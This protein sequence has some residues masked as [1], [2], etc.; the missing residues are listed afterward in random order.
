MVRTSI[1]DTISLKSLSYASVLEI[2]DTERIT[3]LSK[4]LAVQREKELFFGNEGSFAAY[5][6][7]SKNIP[8]PTIYER[9]TLKR[10]NQNPYIKVGDL[11]VR[12]ASSSAVIHIGSTKEIRAESRVK[13]IRQLQG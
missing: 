7:F 3:P 2:G 6:I 5:P 12:G 10:D 13:H 9:I 1:V 4:A 11:D 8:L